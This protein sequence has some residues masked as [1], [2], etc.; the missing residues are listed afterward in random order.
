MEAGGHDTALF[1]EE[2]LAAWTC[3]TCHDVMKHAVSF[4]DN[5]HSSASR[6]VT[7]PVPARARRPSPLSGPCA[8]WT[9]Q[10]LTRWC[11]A[12][13]RTAG[14]CGRTGHISA[15]ALG[16]RGG[17]VF[18]RRSEGAGAARQGTGAVS[19]RRRYGA[20]VAAAEAKAARLQDARR[21][22]ASAARRRT[23]RSRRSRAAKQSR[24]GARRGPATAAVSND[25]LTSQRGR[26]PRG[27]QHR[28]GFSIR[29][30]R[31]RS[32]SRRTPRAGSARQRQRLDPA[33]PPCSALLRAAARRARRAAAAR[34]R[35]GGSGG[36]RCERAPALPRPVRRPRRASTL[37][38]CSMAPPARRMPRERPL[39]RRTPPQRSSRRSWTN[40]T[41]RRRCV[42]NATAE[43]R[44]KRAAAFP[45]ATS[46][47]AETASWRAR[48][49]CARE[50]PAV[51]AEYI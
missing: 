9:I 40:S 48:P 41:G 18:M 35:G 20:A 38:N 23:Q 14:R 31:R 26:P 1:V 46:C 12:A 44:C 51:I 47:S 28:P 25:G 29:R 7:D 32:S 2:P 13:S 6:C 17:G 4:C 36:R 11:A 39:V 30:P 21:G 10:S 37:A 24:F 49:H 15:D 50:R 42:R 34:R 3:V 27:V 45:P 8:S 22:A 33:P 16:I 5:G 43:P 19:G